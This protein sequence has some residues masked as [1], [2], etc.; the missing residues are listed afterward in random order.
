MEVFYQFY[1]AGDL[2]A[3]AYFYLQ[4]HKLFSKILI[5]HFSSLLAPG[6]AIWCGNIS[7]P[8]EKYWGKSSKNFHFLSFTKTFSWAHPLSSLASEAF[9]LLSSAANWF[10]ETHIFLFPDKTQN[11]LTCRELSAHWLHLSSLVSL[12]YSE[13]GLTHNTPRLHGSFV[14]MQLIVLINSPIEYSK[15]EGTLE[16]V[17]PNLSARSPWCCQK[18][19]AGR[20]QIRSR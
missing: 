4:K 15:A 14:V 20:F 10:L 9:Q 8:S 19:K 5:S 7:H 6:V 2:S 3:L 18:L 11:I 16:S 12:L 13:G 1:F 17:D